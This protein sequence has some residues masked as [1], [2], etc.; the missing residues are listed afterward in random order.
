MPIDD[1]ALAALKSLQGEMDRLF[2][3]LF[4]RR[5]AAPRASFTPLADV[6]EEKETEKTIVKI[7]LPGVK[8][9]EL[10]IVIDGRTLIVQ[11]VRRDPHCKG[12]TYHQIEIDRGAFE[13]KIVLPHEV[14]AKSAKASYEDGFLSI[15]LPLPKKE[16]AV[17]IPI[18]VKEV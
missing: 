5:P 2:V 11:G 4:G 14:D 17:K 6:Y 10:N 16:R 3:D 13:R 1:E 9:E 15:E 18:K 12:K 7:E 8:L